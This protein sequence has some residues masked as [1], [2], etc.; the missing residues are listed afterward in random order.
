VKQYHTQGEFI[1]LK[2]QICFITEKLIQKVQVHITGVQCSQVCLE[3]N[4]GRSCR[5]IESD[6]RTKHK[7]QLRDGSDLTSELKPGACFEE[8]SKR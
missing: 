4:L 8:D 3:V 2:R 7:E 5:G 6:T 1:C